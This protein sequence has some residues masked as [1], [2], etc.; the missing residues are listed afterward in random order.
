MN[1][2]VIYRAV[3]IFVVI[4]N[5]HIYVQQIIGHLYLKK[6]KWFLKEKLTRSLIISFITHIVIGVYVMTNDVFLD[7]IT[8][9]VCC[10][11]QLCYNA[12]DRKQV[13]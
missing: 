9:F 2:I 11:A 10:A 5:N 6:K 12:L 1:N 3:S 13:L 7:A 4:I 8:L